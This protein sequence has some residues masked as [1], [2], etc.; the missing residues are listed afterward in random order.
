MLRP[1]TLD[2]ALRGV[3]TAFYL[4]HSM[5]KGK[6]FEAL[7]REGAANFGHAAARAGVSRI[8]YLGGLGDEAGELSPH[9]RSRH[10]TGECLRRGGV[11]VVELRASIII[12]S[13]SL[14]FEMIRALVEKLPFMITPRW[15]RTPTQPIAI[16]D[17]I[18]YLVEA[19]D[20]PLEGS[21][22]FEIG[23]AEVTSYLGIM[24]AYARERGL[25]RLVVPVPVLSPR[26]SS[27]WVGLFTPVY[28]AVGR[29]LIDGVRNATVVR[30]P[31]ALAAF[32][33]RPRGVAEAVRRALINEESDLA[34]TR[35]SDALS[36]YDASPGFGGVRFG[37]RLVDS[38]VVRFHG[39]AGDA[40]API[41]R[42]GGA[43]GWYFADVL[44]RLR[45]MI[46]VLAGG[47]G[48]R[49]GRRDPERLVPGDTVDCWRVEAVEPDRLLR[50]RAE[51]RLPGRAW[52]QFEIEGA[53]PDLRIRQTALFDPRGLS[54]L[55]YW[56]GIYPLH[57]LVFRG[58][59]TAIA[60]RAR[61]DRFRSEAGP[62]YP[63]DS[64]SLGGGGRNLR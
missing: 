53:E 58:M 34:A 51:M 21:Q 47:P 9:L 56:Y 46:D 22:V 24:Q 60:R 17:V 63:L 64:T 50:L 59:L 32:G 62:S 37:S 40:F 36:S 31:S 14:S 2:A 27:L 5:G 7:D 41:R 48:M 3:R 12:G 15:V 45:G 29:K 6:D 42:I 49:R 30:D 57:E 26:L 13:G 10:E 52:L 61:R 35:W 8:V 44:W 18:D 54:G 55:L 39:R 38:R 19:V 4:V 25:R 1:E 28:A 16:E 11:P 23:G 43:N 33:V 20:I